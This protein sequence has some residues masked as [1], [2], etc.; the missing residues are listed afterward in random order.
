[1]IRNYLDLPEICSQIYFNQYTI[2]LILVLVKLCTLRNSL[3]NAISKRLVDDSVCDDDNIQSVLNGIHDVV[4]K[5]IDKL[6]YT[7]LAFI[8]LI[9]KTIRELVIFF[10][11]LFLGTYICLLTAAVTG[12]TEFAFDASESVIQAVNVTVVATVDEIETSLQGLS[13]FLNDL[14]TG[15][16]AIKNLFTGSASTA[17]AQEYQNKINISL[18][19]LKDKI[20]IPGSVLDDIQSARNVSLGELDKI[21]NE[22]QELLETPFNLIIQKLDGI[23]LDNNTSNSSISPMQVKNACLDSVGAVKDSQAV[24]VKAVEEVSK[25][26]LIALAVII[27]GSLAYALYVEMRHWKRSTKFILEEDVSVNEIGFRNQK[28]IYDNPALYTLIKRF[29]IRLNDRLIWMISYMSSPLASV[30][31]AFA[32]MGFISVILQLLL[33]HFVRQALG[34]EMTK[35]ENSNTTSNLGATYIRSMNT[36]INQTQIRLNNELFGEVTATAARIN[37]T[38]AEFVDNLDNAVHEIFGNTIFTQVINTVVYCTIGR[39]LEKIEQGCAW[40]AENLQVQIPAMPESLS[41]DIQNIKFL[42]PQNIMSKLNPVL[43]L[44]LSSINLE[45]FISFCFLVAW[46][47]QFIVALLILYFRQGFS[48]NAM[49]IAPPPPITTDQIGAPRPLTAKEK[50][51]YSYPLSDPHVQRNP[52][53]SSSFYPSPPQSWT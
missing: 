32:I 28:N 30:V 37:S 25:W 42:Q 4:L 18:G 20:A 53:T 45:L 13:K 8:V 43:D 17:Q 34:H 6:Q 50:E 39:K 44:Y 33:V 40:L 46:L 23:K 27:V 52:T 49:A 41:R 36:Y 14:V 47:L 10:I 16:N 12:T 9:V 38:I 24:L 3:I 11:D 2:L 5:N 29:K 31:L 22:T 51:L 26:L 21:N 35:L 1:M 15:F 48:S 19:N 7:G